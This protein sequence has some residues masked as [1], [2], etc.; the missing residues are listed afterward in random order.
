MLPFTLQQLKI[1]KIIATE[2][3]FTKAAKNLYISQPAISKQIKALEKNLGVVLLKRE[4]NRIFLTENGRVLLQYSERIL[5]LCE[6]S[7]RA[8]VDLKSGSRGNLTIGASEIIGTY[9]IPR[10]VTLFT[11][12]Y[13]QINLEVEVNSISF[14]VNSIIQNKIDIG[15]IEGDIS[16]NLRKKLRVKLFANEEINL[17]TPKSHSYLKIDKIKKEDLYYL[18]F[19]TLSSDSDIGKFIDT[20][21]IQN[22]IKTRQLKVIMQFNSI[23]AIKIAVRLGLG[24]AF[25]P[26]V[27]VEKEVELELVK[28]LRIDNTYI[29]RTFSIVSNIDSEQ[30]KSFEYFYKELM[31]LKDKLEN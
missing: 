13:P 2:K 21:L 19:I 30:S 20:L 7:C 22:Q 14:I 28:I 9:L 5:A 27:T 4:N 16:P 10:I 11:Q 24:V 8:L 1:L 12:N 23:E 25:I 18:N 31:V 3:S 6:E 26:S 29:N 17:I 15:I